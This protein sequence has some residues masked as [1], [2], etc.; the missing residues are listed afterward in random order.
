MQQTTSISDGSNSSS[1][2]LLRQKERNLLDAL[3]ES[4]HQLS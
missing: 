1:E 2:I 4:S 3:E